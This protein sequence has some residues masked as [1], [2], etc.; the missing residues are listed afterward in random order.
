MFPRS[1]RT[2]DLIMRVR[3]VHL[4][5]RDEKQRLYG[6]VSAS[7]EWRARTLNEFRCVE[8][9]LLRPILEYRERYDMQ[10]CLGEDVMADGAAT[11]RVDRVSP[12]VSSMPSDT[13]APRATTAAGRGRW[14][15]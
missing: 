4:K 15:V 6:S 3:A 13:R 2:R 10:R 14:G 9:S 8:P 11:A 12:T 5:R 7:S 1:S